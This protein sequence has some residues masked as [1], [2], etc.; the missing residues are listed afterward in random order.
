MLNL[1]ETCPA[2]GR[3]PSSPRSILIAEDDRKTSSLLLLY[4]ERAG[5]QAVPAFDGQQALALARQRQPALIILDLLLPIMNGWAVCREV[6]CFSKVPIL[7]LSARGEIQERVDGL[8]LGADD[9]V[10]KP[11]SPEELV[12]RVRAILR[13]AGSE[14]EAGEKL[15]SHNGL[16]LDPEKHRVSLD[17]H[18]VSLTPFE[19]RLLHALMAAPGRIFL[20]EELLR[21]LYPA[22]E[23]VVDRVIDVHIGNLRQK[24][25]KDH[26]SPQYV[27]TA[28][29]LGYQFTD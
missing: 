4:L 22:G 11:F 9:Y 12:A 15:L 10:V 28:R 14:S 3:Y 23:A 5:F 16:V 17:G 7:I 1:L 20:R 18:A 29:G 2:P 25:E 21:Y 27:L 19:Y 8:S 6:R 13:R 24:I 26:A